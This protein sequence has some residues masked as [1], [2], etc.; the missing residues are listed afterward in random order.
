[1]ILTKQKSLRWQTTG[2]WRCI[3]SCIKNS[4]FQELLQ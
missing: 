2:R 3:C 4:V 1:M